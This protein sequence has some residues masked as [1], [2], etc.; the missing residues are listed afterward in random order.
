MSRPHVATAEA[1]DRF[2][3]KVVLVAGGSSGIGRAA[4]ARM[5]AEGAAVVI[6]ARRREAGE[7]AA[8]SC[9]EAGGRAEFVQADLTVEGQAAVVVQAAVEAY[10]RLD[11]AFNNVG[12]V[13]GSG[14]VADL[15]AQQ[16]HA[17]LALNLTSVFWCVK[18]QV[19][20]I[21]AS[22]GGA[23]VNNAS[24]AGGVGVPGMAAYTAAKHG[25]VGLTRAAALEWADRGVRLNALLTG[26]VDTPLFRRLVGASDETD[27]DGSGLNPSGRVA[28]AEEVAALVAFLLSDE[29]PFLTGATVPIDGG[30]SAG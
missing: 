5:A 16:W 9:R 4:A 28:D 3:S 25:V 8:A 30:F 2:A 7:A 26:N 24:V 1:P 12:G 22:G 20:A 11:G 21:A 18:H 29:A 17:E 27:L 15:T 14:P 10:G 19:P 23:I 6:A 13:A